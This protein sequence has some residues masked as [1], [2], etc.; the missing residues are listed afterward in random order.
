MFKPSVAISGISCLFALA[1]SLP[2]H[3]GLN[4]IS[5]REASSGLKLALTRSA[6]IAVDQLGQ[7]DGFL[8]N[9][10]VRIPLPRALQK[11]EGMA[12]LVGLSGPADELVTTMNRAAESAVVEARPLL[13]HAVKTMSITD[14][15]EI[16]T[17]SEDA[18]TRYFRKSS[19]AALTRKFRPIVK[20]ATAQVNLADKYNNYARMAAQFGLI[21]VEDADLDSYVTKKALDGLF[22]II[23]EQ[24]KLIRQDPV[25][26]G[27]RLLQKVFGAL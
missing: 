20:Q 1:M 22:L 4:D 17:G 24:E 3:A 27:S 9:A 5:K 2:L 25:G 11:I 13:V 12:R 8:G 16:L 10:K 6:E 18:A 19:S 15:L 14:A 21:N 26:S 23:A 7:P